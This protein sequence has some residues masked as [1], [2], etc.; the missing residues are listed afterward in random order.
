M[1]ERQ[2][3]LFDQARAFV[4]A[5]PD[6]Y[7]LGH[8]WYCFY[9]RLWAIRGENVLLD[10]LEHP[11]EL[12][13]LTQALLD[14][15]VKAV[16]SSRPRA[17]T[18]SS[19]PT[20]SARSAPSL[21]SPAV[22]RRIL[23]PFYAE[24]IREIHGLGMHFGCACG[25]LTAIIGDFVEIGLDVL[26]PI[27]AHTMDY[28]AVAERFGGKISFLSGRGCPAPA[29]GGHRGGGARVREVA[30]I[31]RRPE[32]AAAGR[33]TALCRRHH[34]ATSVHFWKKRRCCKEVNLVRT[35]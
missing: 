4:A 9:E 29:A 33:A 19:R 16:R 5:H 32:G 15:H 8:W 31:F 17:W 12:K 11:V 13:R 2:T 14:H 28:A 23:K 18:A 10:F 21:M 6:Q 3:G 20:T 34:C 22:F 30:R 27:Q 25:N 7:V 26:H 35:R 1:L 24:F